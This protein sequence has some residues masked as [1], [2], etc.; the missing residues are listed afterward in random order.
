MRSIQECVC[1]FPRTYSAIYVSTNLNAFVV[2]ALVDGRMFWS[3]SVSD[4]I[5]VVSDLRR[6]KRSYIPSDCSIGVRKYT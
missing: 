1:V 6:E 2:R 3:D 4:K 5:C